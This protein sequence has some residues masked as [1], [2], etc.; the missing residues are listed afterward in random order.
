MSDLEGVVEEKFKK[1]NGEVSSGY[2]SK[3]RS[4][5]KRF[6]HVREV[7]KLNED[8]KGMKLLEEL[9]EKA[10]NYVSSVVKVAIPPRQLASMETWELQEKMTALDRS[11]RISHDALISQLTILN[12]YLFKNYEAG[13]EIPI[14]GIY[15]LPP[16][17][18]TAFDRK[19]VGDWAGY[20]VLGLYGQ[21]KPT[22]E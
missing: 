12:R 2:D 9:V 15:S 17:T 22:K 18:L 1:M 8:E 20:L 19:A 3:C 7:L 11:R 21:R 14:G 5:Y 13:E 16:D 10:N 6:E 4:A